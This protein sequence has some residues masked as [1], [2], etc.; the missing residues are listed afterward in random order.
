MKKKLI[1]Y[2][3]ALYQ[4]D[5]INGPDYQNRIHKYLR[6]EHEK[7]TKKELSPDWSF[8]DVRHTKGPLQMDGRNCG[9]H[10]I[11]IVDA[12]CTLSVPPEV[13]FLFEDWNTTSED[14][15]KYR[16]RLGHLILKAELPAIQDL[17]TKIDKEL[18]PSPYHKPSQ[19]D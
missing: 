4:T 10:I 13:L 15:D 1:Y 16:Y 11:L 9:P 2:Y 8:V 7:I 5:T 18:T 12:I 17:P 6:Q 3:D 19:T 14:L